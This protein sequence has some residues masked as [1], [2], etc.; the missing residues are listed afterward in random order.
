MFFKKKPK[1]SNHF[2]I[3]LALVALVV[4]LFLLGYWQFYLNN[5]SLIIREDEAEFSPEWENR[6]PVAINTNKREDDVFVSENGETI[7]YTQGA[8]VY[9]SL[10]PFVK[11]QKHPI[12]ESSW[13]ESGLM[14]AGSDVY[15]SSDRN[16]Q[17]QFDLYKNG[18]LL[19]F[20]NLKLNESDPFYCVKENILYFDANGVIFST[21]DNK[22]AA[23]PAPINGDSKNSDPFLI[24]DCQTMYFVSDRG[25]GVLKIFR[26]RQIAKDA[27]GEPEAVVSGGHGVKSPSLTE[28]EQ[29]LFFTQ[30]F[31]APNGRINADIFYATKK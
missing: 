23:L 15:Y 8:D 14:L 11:V 20:S 5:W 7:Y 25:D 4:F 27:W 1:K 3:K 19:D 31:K 16:H 17:N 26:S 22:V 9:Y 18:R 6:T 21:Q 29:T 2:A 13:S 30:I 10:K 24:A 12:S 28:D